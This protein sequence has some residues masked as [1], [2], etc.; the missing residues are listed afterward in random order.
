M[1]AA[2]ILY[3]DLVNLVF[4]QL[5]GDIFA[6]KRQDVYSSEFCR[7]AEPDLQVLP[8]CLLSE[9]FNTWMWVGI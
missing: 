7:G 3:P 6:W 5:L 2:P 1:V 8:C 4:E 9:F